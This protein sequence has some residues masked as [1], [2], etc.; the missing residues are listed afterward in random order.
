MHKGLFKPYMD[1]LTTNLVFEHWMFITLFGY[2]TLYYIILIHLY[3]DS[4]N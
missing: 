3:N 1:L 2:P 4:I